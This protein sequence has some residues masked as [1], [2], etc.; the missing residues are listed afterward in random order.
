MTVIL[1]NWVC[2][3]SD[4]DC[5]GCAINSNPQ[6]TNVDMAKNV[7]YVTLMPGEEPPDGWKKV[8]LK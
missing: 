5:S 1:E 4:C 6:T 3:R 2:H 7:L 8:K